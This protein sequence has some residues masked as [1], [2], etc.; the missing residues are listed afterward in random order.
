MSLIARKPTQELIDLVG[1]LGGTWSGASALCRCP[2]HNDR[3]PSLSLRQG[4]HGFLV[5]CYAGC[6]S[7][8]VLRALR[9]IVPKRSHTSPAWQDAPTRSSNIARIWNEGLE[10]KGSLAESYLRSRK[11]PSN[12]PDLRFHPRCPQGPSPLTQ[13]KPALLVAVREGWKLTAIQRIFLDPITGAYTQKLMI[14]SPGQG[15]WQGAVP[16]DTLAIAESMEDAAA[17]M[18]Q[19][20]GPCWSALGAAR[21]HLL[22]LPATVT[23]I[24]IAEDNDAEGR[25]AAR[26]AWTVYRERGLMVRRMKPPEPHKDW[27]AVNAA[28]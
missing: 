17:F 26:R 7:G 27:A 6:D 14:G 25:R 24:V 2:A 5:Y 12:Y 15:A 18:A 8:Q 20:H 16:T 23:T 10:I 13:F 21:L 3:T 28:P 4:D 11:L 9:Q 1:A 22:A 19:G